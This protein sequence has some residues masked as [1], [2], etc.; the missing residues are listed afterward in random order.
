MKEHG[1]GSGTQRVYIVE[2]R[3]TSME[4][5]CH[6]GMI[7]DQRWRRVNFARGAPGVPVNLWNAE[8][9]RL[10]FLNYEA[11]LALA[12]WFLAAAGKSC[13]WSID[14]R[15]VQI[16]FSYKYETKECGIGPAMNH[17]EMIRAAKWEP[18]DQPT[19]VDDGRNAGK[20]GQ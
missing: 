7:L 9:E 15:L 18:R 2:A 13:G 8:A 3:S 12:F 6:G 11:A 5:Q 16:E 1:S 20:K 4:P 14:V 19:E 17:F 10:G